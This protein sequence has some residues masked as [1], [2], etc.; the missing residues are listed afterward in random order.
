MKKN[1]HFTVMIVPE[2]NGKTITFRLPKFLI[3]I[4]C[5]IILLFFIGFFLIVIKSG[6][7]AA[8]LQ[9]HSVVKSENEKL[10]NENDELRKIVERLNQLSQF[11]EYLYKLAIPNKNSE[12][13]NQ[14]EL[15]SIKKNSDSMD[16]NILVANSENLKYSENIDK[17]PNIVPVNG[18]ITKHFSVDGI[19][20]NQRHLGIDFAA[21]TGTPIKA[22]AEG[23]IKN[24]TKD[25]YLGLIITVDHDGGLETRYGHCSQ[26]IVAKHDY[27]KKGQTIALV[28][29]TGRSSAPHLHYE[30]LKDGIHVNPA[31]Y[32]IEHK[33]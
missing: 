15:R 22:T 8:K 32:I 10:I 25:K 21:A 17:Y 13:K 3:I 18:W 6:E 2:E 16:L 29:N 30:I 27:V 1:S 11:S 14:L 28:G 9:M 33:D 5:I 12:T 23:I 20:G 7:I 31:N 19:N 24:I 4:I 26:I